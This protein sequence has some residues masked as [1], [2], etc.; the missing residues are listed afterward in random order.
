MRMASRAVASSVLLVLLLIYTFGIIVHML[1]KGDQRVIDQFETL[2]RSMWTLLMVGTFMDGTSNLMGL[3][4][5][6]NE[7]NALLAVCLLLLFILVSA[8]T[9]MNMLIGVLC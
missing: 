4:L 5:T 7:L 2:P 6:S 8:V 9:V 1:L 3:L